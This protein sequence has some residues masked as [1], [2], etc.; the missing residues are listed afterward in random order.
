MNR[1]DDRVGDLERQVIKLTKAVKILLTKVKDLE[2]AATAATRSIAEVVPV[3][4]DGP[5]AEVWASGVLRLR[6]KPRRTGVYADDGVCL[7]CGGPKAKAGRM[8]CSP[9]AAERA[10]R[11]TRD[12]AGRPPLPS[13]PECLNCGGAKAGTGLTYLC[14]ECRKASKAA[15]L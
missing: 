5:S 15:G 12:A 8:S 3:V 7:V 9:C 11:V 4:E 2:A 1:M 6:R 13:V 14:S 10:K